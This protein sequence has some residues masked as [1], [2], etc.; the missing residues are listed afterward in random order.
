MTNLCPLGSV[1]SVSKCIS[2]FL[3]RNADGE[4]TAIL[5]SIYSLPLDLSQNC[6]VRLVVLEEPHNVNAAVWGKT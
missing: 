1:P 5:P 6:W 2:L 4:L 3:P